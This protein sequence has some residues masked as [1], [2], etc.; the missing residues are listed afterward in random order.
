MTQKRRNWALL[1]LVVSLIGVI[2]LS[3]AVSNMELSSEW[4]LYD[5]DGDE[6]KASRST[7]GEFLNRL[8][9]LPEALWQV[10]SIVGV[11]FIP[12][13]IMMALF[14]PEIRK[15][16]FNEIKRVVPLVAMLVVILYLLNRIQLE[17]FNQAG[18]NLFE[19]P[20]DVPAWI[21]NPTAL[22]AFIIGVL[23]LSLIFLLSYLVWRKSQA[24]SLGRIANE[25]QVTIDQLKAGADY[26]N[27]II[28]CYYRMCVVLREHRRIVR[29]ES[30]TAREFAQQLERLGI[31]GW[32]AHR[33]TKLF[34]SV[35]YGAR[36]SH[37][38]DEF[39]AIECLTAITQLTEKRS[40]MLST[41]KAWTLEH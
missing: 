14:S 36:E 27:T 25:A 22:T 20:P 26:K 18:S 9:E 3:T 34:E 15:T 29:K 28:E 38:E 17:N 37:R 19:N 6:G 40:R 8:P 16:L 11:I 1:F 23:A 13:A 21:T 10:L 24:R 2:T 12:M 32:H 7:A 5:Y 31:S 35:R 33:L 39:E 30:M 41:S 4:R